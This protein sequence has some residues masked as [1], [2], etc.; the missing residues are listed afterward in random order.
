MNETWIDFSHTYK[1][2]MPEAYGH[3][4]MKAERVNNKNTGSRITN[5]TFNS[6]CGTHI[7]AP[8][9]YVEEGKTIDSFSPGFFHGRA[10]VLNLTKTEFQPIT[11]QD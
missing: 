1:E 11:Y 7:D 8:Y 10:A 5:I 4:Q 6:H 3:T 2:G 9:H